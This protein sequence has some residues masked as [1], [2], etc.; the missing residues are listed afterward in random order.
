MAL[1]EQACGFYGE[2]LATKHSMAHR[3]RLLE[4]GM[5]RDGL[6]DMQA[7][8]EQLQRAEEALD[9]CLGMLKALKTLIGTLSPGRQ[10]VEFETSSYLSDGSSVG[11]DCVSVTGLSLSF[12]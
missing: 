3:L 6:G 9:E 11:S 4:A 1:I 7:A 10:Q 5:V 8:R 2:R 12:D